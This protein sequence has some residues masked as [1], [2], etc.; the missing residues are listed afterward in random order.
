[1]KYFMLIVAICLFARQTDAV[2][3][4]DSTSPVT[5]GVA[6][7]N[8]SSIALKFMPPNEDGWSTERSGLSVTLKKNA[9]SS[10]D[11]REIEAYLIRMDSP[12][13]PISTYIETIKRNIVESYAN[14]K[15][16]KIALL[17]IAE[18]IKDN[19][20]AKGHLLLE[21]TQPDEATNERKWS[22]QYFLSCGLVK[23]KGLG[24][25]L[26]YYHRYVD[27]TRDKQF[28]EDAHQV[29]ETVTIEDN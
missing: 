10:S 29:L 24:F 6:D 1:M 20:C 22:E 3:N 15:T 9:T 2:E 26:R 12:N 21:A 4:K 5:I 18:D 17:D 25:E 28:I 23:H 13:S 14:N 16:F 8:G 19:R 7:S 11:N 27:S